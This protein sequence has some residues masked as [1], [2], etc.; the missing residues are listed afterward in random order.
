MMGAMSTVISDGI[1]HEAKTRRLKSAN[2]ALYKHT[3]Y[4]HCLLF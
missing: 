4:K 3:A 2:I 1:I